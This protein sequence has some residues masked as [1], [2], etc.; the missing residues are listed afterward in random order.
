MNRQE[1]A[2]RIAEQAGFSQTDANKMIGAF[3]DSVQAAVAEGEKVALVGFGTFESSERSARVGKNPQTG[4]VVN[5]PAR[6][7][8]K[9]SA[10]KVFKDAVKG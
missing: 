4:A 2:K 9:F 6:K 10:S 3:I 5:I 1:L 7:V 8:P